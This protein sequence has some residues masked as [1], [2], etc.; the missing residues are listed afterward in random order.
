MEKQI[1]YFIETLIVP[2]GGILVLLIVGTILL[3]RGHRHSLK[4]LATGVVLLY[5]ASAPPVADFLIGTLEH[6]PALPPDAVIP[7]DERAAIVILGGGRYMDAPEFGADT[8]GAITLERI[9]YGARLARRTRLPVLVTGGTVWTNRVAE[10][11]LM[12][13]TLKQDFGV[14][15]RW[16]EGASR[17]SWE[18]ARFSKPLLDA[19]GITKVYLV[20]HAWHM[21]RSVYAFEQAGINVIPAPTAFAN[22]GDDDRGALGLLPDASA[23]RRSNYA[24]HEIIG[25][26]WYRVKAIFA[27]PPQPHP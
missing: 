22:T 9:R 6:V 25:L 7:A 23:M 8:V 1:T 18:N 11:E 13:Q 24:A 5:L 16:I 27:S 19:A 12:G 2:P 26:L 17:T 10:A 14:E 15:A 4:I 21:P 20:T 3:Y